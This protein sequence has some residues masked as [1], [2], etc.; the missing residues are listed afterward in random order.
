MLKL[1]EQD[2]DLLIWLDPHCFLDLET[3]F[4]TVS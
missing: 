4:S 2:S 3:S 1:L